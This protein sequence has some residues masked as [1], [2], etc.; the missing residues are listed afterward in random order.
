MLAEPSSNASAV[1]AAPQGGLARQQVVGADAPEIEPAAD[2]AA[3]GALGSGSASSAAVPQSAP[4]NALPDSGFPVKTKVDFPVLPPHLLHEVPALA[5]TASKDNPVTEPRARALI[6]SAAI[7]L[8]LSGVITKK[9]HPRVIEHFGAMLHAVLPH[10]LCAT[11]KGKT[12]PTGFDKRIA[13][14]LIDKVRRKA[15]GWEL[16]VPAGTVVADDF[17]LTRLAQLSRLKI[18]VEGVE[19]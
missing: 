11:P 8:L 16:E 12:V 9:R 5:R 18:C 13:N 17:L 10:A 15:S 4:D 7:F 6:T 2:G 1:E 19:P 14:W 3:G